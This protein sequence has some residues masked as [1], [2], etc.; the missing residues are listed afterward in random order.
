MA[1]HWNQMTL[2]YVIE[3]VLQPIIFDELTNELNTVEL[4]S[5]VNGTR[6]FDGCSSNF[7]IVMVLL[8]C[9]TYAIRFTNFKK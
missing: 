2:L 6:L 9:R 7:L 4:L 1:K 5:R 8:V 3:I